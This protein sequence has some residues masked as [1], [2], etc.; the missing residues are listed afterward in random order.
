MKDTW[1]LSSVVIVKVK[2]TDAKKE[3]E[4]ERAREREREKNAFPSAS[5]LSFTLSFVGL[6]EVLQFLR[7]T[8]GLPYL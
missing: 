7:Q 2:Q 4:R 3:S 5:L 1:F 6:T 8:Q